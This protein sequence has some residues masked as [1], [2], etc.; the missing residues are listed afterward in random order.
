[1]HAHHVR[2]LVVNPTHL[3]HLLFH[4]RVEPG[5]VYPCNHRLQDALLAKQASPQKHP[6]TPLSLQA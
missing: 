5:A 1:M 6:D 3:Q 2:T 4:D